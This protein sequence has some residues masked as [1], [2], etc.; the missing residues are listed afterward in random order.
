MARNLP[1]SPKISRATNKTPPK[2]EL[3]IVCEGKNTEPDYILSCAEHYGNGLVTIN[4][5][6]AAGVPLT[7]IETALELR[8]KLTTE[9]KKSRNSFDSCFRVWAIFD[10]DEH[11]HVD[12]AL[13][14]AAEKKL[15][16]AFSNPCF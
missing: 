14:I 15:D 3:F 8:E 2:V 16:V 9:R 6:R 4:P 12:K 5:I 7:I 10:R 11:P 13:M 1:S